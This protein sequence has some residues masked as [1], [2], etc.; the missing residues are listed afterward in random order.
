QLDR[1]IQ[2]L[3][4][5]LD[6]VPGENGARLSTGQKQRIAIARAFLRD[7]EILILD[8]ATSALDARTEAEVLA[9]LSDLARG[10]TT[11]SVTHRVV[12]AAAADQIFVFDSGQLVEYGTHDE[13]ISHDK[14]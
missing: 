4:A 9:T 5:G 3:P 1:L 12:Q 13:L 6:T 10:R 8:E 2:S 7:P 11:I 14:L